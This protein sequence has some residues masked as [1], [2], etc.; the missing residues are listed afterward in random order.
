MKILVYGFGNPGRQDDGAGVFLAEELEKWASAEGLGDISFE[1]AYQ[2]NIED[3]ELISH[4]DFVIFADASQ[5]QIDGIIYTDVSPGD[6]RVEFTM[7]AVSVS[8]VL[9]LCGKIYHKFPVTSLLH[10]KGHEWE[11]KEGLSMRA[12]ENLRK[13][14]DF[15]RNEILR[16]Y[17]QM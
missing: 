3:A 1:T 13:A 10:I 16:L 9:D 6:S 5:E 12:E 4:F 2:L 17:F 14:F 7:H 8:Y 15:A 11:L